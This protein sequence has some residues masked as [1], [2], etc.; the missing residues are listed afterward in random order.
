MTDRMV[1]PL[2]VF[3]PSATKSDWFKAQRG[4]DI[5]NTVNALLA[6]RAAGRRDLR[7]ERFV[8]QHVLPD[9][10]VS[11]STARLGTCVE[12]SAA[13]ALLPSANRV[14]LRRVLRRLALPGSHWPTFILDEDS[15]YDTYLTGP[16]VTAWAV[17]ALGPRAPEVPA[18]KAYL[19][20]LLDHH[21]IWSAHP[22][23]YA[24]PFYPAH[25]AVP[26]VRDARVLAYTLDTQDR[27]GAWGFGDPP[28]D[29]SPLPTALAL[30]ALSHFRATPDVSR[31][32]AGARAWLMGAQSA[33]GSFPLYPAPPELWYT[34]A[35]YVTSIAIRALIA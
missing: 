11:H 22:A 34:G 15:G 28:G 21:P 24:T 31:V 17:R 4:A 20:G 30:L 25:L 16:S 32:I 18:A 33:D 10:S 26:I 8:A 14:R 6:L 2:S 9:G 29:P 13:W 5:W 12:T 27:S 3:E 35:V 7:A 23:F 1:N 19:R